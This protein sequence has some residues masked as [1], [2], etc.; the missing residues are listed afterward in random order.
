M[1]VIFPVVLALVAF[2]LWA[3]KRATKAGIENIIMAEG[4]RLEPYQDAGKWAVG[5]GHQ[6]QPGEWWDRITLAQA[7]DLLR[8]DLSK[9]ER[10]IRELVKVPLRPGQFDA[11]VSLTYNIGP[12]AFADSTLLK[13]LNAGDYAG[14]A[15]EFPKWRLSQGEINPAL[16]ARRAKEQALFTA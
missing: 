1:N 13:K 8:G 14:A 15:A 5:F 9:T 2:G 11:L 4:V 6:L 10:R 12:T 3:R 7:I 16:V